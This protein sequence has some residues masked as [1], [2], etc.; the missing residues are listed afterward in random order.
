MTDKDGVVVS[1]SKKEVVSVTLGPPDPELF[2]VPAD[3]VERTPSEVYRLDAERAGRAICE[4]CGT[5]Q[6]L[7]NA[8]LKYHARRNGG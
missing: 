5:N 6:F 4:E 2:E 3:Y 8:D 7:Q 1:R